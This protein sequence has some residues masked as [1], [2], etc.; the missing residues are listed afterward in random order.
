MA[1][2]PKKVR[3]LLPAPAPVPIPTD[4]ISRPTLDRILD[5]LLRANVGSTA[6]PMLP[7]TPS[8]EV[9]RVLPICSREDVEGV[10]C[11]GDGR[12]KE[13]CASPRSTNELVLV[14]VAVETLVVGGEEKEC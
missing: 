1:F 11:A 14:L 4:N 5:L 2:S 10:G 7:T 13:V 9:R 6:G 12:V 3:E 8:D